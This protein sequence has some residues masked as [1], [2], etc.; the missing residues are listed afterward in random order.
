M[1][2]AKDI[3]QADFE[4][5][6]QT[7]G[8]VFIDFWAPWCGPC[9]V[10]GPIIDQMILEFPSVNFVKVNVDDEGE[11]ANN[12]GVQSIPTFYMLNLPGDGT[13]DLKRDAIGKLIGAVSAFDF[14]VAIEK[15]LEK[16]SQ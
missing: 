14:K 12:F 8:L 4:Q 15:T 2:V 3:S 16:V 6:K 5:L 13:F 7:K 1:S 9:K 11:M 10:M